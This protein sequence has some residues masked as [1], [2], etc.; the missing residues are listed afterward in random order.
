[1]MHPSHLSGH[2]TC[3]RSMATPWVCVP[4]WGFSFCKT[5]VLRT[6][7]LNPKGQSQCQNLISENFFIFFFFLFI[8][9]KRLFCL[10]TFMFDGCQF[11]TP[12][13]FTQFFSVALCCRGFITE[14]LQRIC[15]ILV[16]G[17]AYPA[18]SFP[19]KDSCPLCVCEH[20]RVVKF[21]SSRASCGCPEWKHHLVFSC[22]DRPC[23]F[24]IHAVP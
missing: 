5:N 24:D 9:K 12:S 8:F 11:F 17:H 22:P 2:G 18:H 15:L 6:T 4:D 16:R 23:T 10:P 20:R 14:D 21:L 1:M 19:R 3:I 7:P 13:L